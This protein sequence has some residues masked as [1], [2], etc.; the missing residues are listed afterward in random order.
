MSLRKITSVKIPTATPSAAGTASSDSL[1]TIAGRLLAVYVKYAA[2]SASTT[3][4]TITTKGDKG[5]A[6]T[7]L[8]LTDT[9]TSGWYYPRHQVHDATGTG[10]TYDGTNE[11]YDIVPILDQVNVA[12]AQ[13]TENKTVDVTLLMETF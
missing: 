2:S 13:A 7:L 10:I 9:N 12:V 11:V 6:N 3:D 1:T 5:G 4:V 8:T